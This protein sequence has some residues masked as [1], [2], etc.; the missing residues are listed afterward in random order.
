MTSRLRRTVPR[1]RRKLFAAV[2][3]ARTLDWGFYLDPEPRPRLPP[4]GYPGKL[5]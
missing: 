3:V 5:V 4:V 1:V 2:T